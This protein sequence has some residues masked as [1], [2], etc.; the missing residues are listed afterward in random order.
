MKFFLPALLFLSSLLLLRAAPGV[1][2][3]PR[4]DDAP[5]E[6]VDSVPAL[7]PRT[8]LQAGVSRGSV[9]VMLH[10]S[11]A[12]ELVDTLITAYSRKAFADE[13]RRVIPKWKFL[14]ARAQ[15]VPAWCGGMLETGIGRAPNLALAAP[16]GFAF[17]GDTSA[18]ARYFA[19]DITADARHR[20]RTAAGRPTVLHAHETGSVRG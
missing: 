9:H 10:V 20:R 12:G 1:A 6:V 4:P 14:P 2:P 3:V 8:M 11:A 15:G 17:P 19:E 7:F 16:P 5:C 13:A 18:S